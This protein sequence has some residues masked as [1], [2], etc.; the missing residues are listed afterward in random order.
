M[1]ICLVCQGVDANEFKKCTSFYPEAQ[2]QGVVSGQKANA[3]GFADNSPFKLYDSID[4]LIKQAESN[5]IHI[6]GN[7][8]IRFG[9][10]LSLLNSGIHV[11]LETPLTLPSDQVDKQAHLHQPVLR[12]M[13]RDITS[14]HQRSSNRV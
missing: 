3:Q 7:V 14:S 5:L 8:D 2:V 13:C 12:F 9:L 11:V 10:V 1:K 6:F 4:E